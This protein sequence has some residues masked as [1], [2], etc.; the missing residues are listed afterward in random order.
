MA[1]RR[2]LV[3]LSGRYDSED[4]ENL[5]RPALQSAL[6]I[7]RDFDAHIEV[8][9]VIGETSKPDETMPAWMPGYGV[10]QVIDWMKTE[11]VARRR[12]ARAAF[13]EV[14]S[15]C[16]P[17]E[18][19]QSSPSPRFSANF[20][21]QVGEIRQTVGEYGR[22][23][24]LIVTASSRARWET[25]YRPVLEA[26]LRRTAR[27]VLVSP[28]SALS[29]VGK[30][31]AV[32]WNDSIESARAVAASL[33]FLQRAQSVRVISCREHSIDDHRVDAVTEYLALHGIE[34]Q[35]VQLEAS[36]KQAASAIVA[37][38]KNS[39]CDLIVMGAYMHTRT[40]ALLFGS[41]TEHVLRDP[42]LPTLIVP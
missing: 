30:D 37:S 19:G 11:G 38:A 24:D 27:P 13:D 31:V 9:C 26:C 4:P 15:A 34:G 40:H 42:I 28:A 7:G 36:S 3:P 6:A 22:L 29:T 14:F 33:L 18:V 25:P 17:S 23:S 41:L 8:L 12:R 2:I 10:N 5:D 32:A 20:V 39:G 16:D 35:A 1:I 21:E